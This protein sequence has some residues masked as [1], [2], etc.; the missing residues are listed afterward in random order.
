MN[1]YIQYFKLACRALSIGWAGTETILLLQYVWWRAFFYGLDS[2]N[3]VAMIDINS[4]GEAHI[5][6]VFWIFITPIIIYGSYLNIIPIIQD[7]D[8]IYTKNYD[9]K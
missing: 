7:F 1:V 3:F 2:G 4:Y 8:K 5:E 6:M 9:K